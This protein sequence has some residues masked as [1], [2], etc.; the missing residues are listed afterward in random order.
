ME[1]AIDDLLPESETME[2]LIGDTQTVNFETIPSSLASALTISDNYKG[3]T[4]IV[5]AVQI[6]CIAINRLQQ[7]FGLHFVPW[8]SC[9]PLCLLICEKNLLCVYS[10]K[11]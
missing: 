1:S 9:F 2:C 5:F 4:T 3:N 11:S 6:T 10:D 7:S 8:L